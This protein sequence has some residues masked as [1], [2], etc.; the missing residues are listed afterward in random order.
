MLLSRRLIPSP[1]P[2]PP[3]LSPRLTSFLDDESIVR[4][5]KEKKGKRK[6]CVSFLW[7]ILIS[8]K[9]SD[10]KRRKGGKDE[11][12]KGSWICTGRKCTF[13][14]INNE[15]TLIL[16]NVV[17]ERSWKRFININSSPFLF[18]SFFFFKF[19]VNGNVSSLTFFH[20]VFFFLAFDNRKIVWKNYDNMLIIVYI[21]ICFGRIGNMDENDIVINNSWILRNLII[22]WIYISLI[23][24]QIFNILYS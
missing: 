6:E 13:L 8:D 21:Y 16:G 19:T 18:F 22:T 7:S 11:R 10:N 2:P 3:S 15:S 14:F 24:F 23:K 1:L 4:K 9:I 12:G 20:W 5:I 17:R